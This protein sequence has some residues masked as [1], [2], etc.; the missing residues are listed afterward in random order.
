MKYTRLLLGSL[1]VVLALWVI[2]GEQISGASANAFIN[3]RLV[4]VHSDVAGRVEMTAR[5]LG[6]RIGEGEV[7]ASVTDPLVD[8][9]R[10]ND[11]LM[12]QGFLVAEKGRL[13][14]NKRAMQD[15]L[16][17]LETRSAAF[18]RHRI[19]ELTIRLDHARARLALLEEEDTPD[20]VAEPALD[21]VDAQTG[22]LPGEPQFPALA[23]DH[24]R[25]RV[26]VIEVSL[27]AAQSG[28]FLGDGYNDAPNAEQRAVEL[29]SEIAT[30]NAA[31]EGTAKR[32]EAVATRI[33]FERQRVNGLRGGICPRRWTG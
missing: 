25:E 23:L 11:L 1:V 31:I 15:I 16:T 12:E 21:A 28:V 32:L 17:A 20:E 33:G 8:T 30:T 29:R 13:E 5:P 24:A 6:A 22:R 18:S 10:V 14:D 3:A 4:T 19:E 9:V 2:V 27:R 7:V 26:E